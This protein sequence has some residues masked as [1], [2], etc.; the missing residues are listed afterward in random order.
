[1]NGI[2]DILIIMK[3]FGVLANYANLLILGTSKSQVSKC[4][5]DYLK[6]KFNSNVHNRVT[7]NY[8]DFIYVPNLGIDVDLLLTLL[9]VGGT[10]LIELPEQ[11]HNIVLR[12]HYLQINNALGLAKN[13]RN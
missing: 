11:S 5:Y 7:D 1:M 4:L 12:G 8:Y 10:I 13:E 6:K 2:K 3:N 9:R